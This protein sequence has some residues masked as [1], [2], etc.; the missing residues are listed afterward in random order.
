[1]I[2]E[3]ERKEIEKGVYR[4]TSTLS[5]RESASEQKRE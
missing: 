3:K 4:D 5:E 2:L 1:M